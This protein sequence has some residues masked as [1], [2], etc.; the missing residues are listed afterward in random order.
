MM[1]TPRMTR[2]GPAVSGCCS[3][4]SSKAPRIGVPCTDT[5]QVRG[6][7]ISMPPHIAKQSSTASPLLSEALRRSTFVPPSPAVMSPPRKSAALL[8]CSV[9]PSMA[10]EETRAALSDGAASRARCCRPPQTSRRPTS[11]MRTGQRWISRNGITPRFC[12]RNQRPISTRMKPVNR[13]GQAAGR[14]RRAVPMAMRKSG[15]NRQALSTWMTPRLSSRA[16]RPSVTTTRPRN[17]RGAFSVLRSPRV[18]RS[19]SIVLLRTRVIASM[20][21]EYEAREARSRG[22]R[23][24]EARHRRTV[25]D[26]TRRAGAAGAARDRAQ[27]RAGPFGPALEKRSESGRLTAA[28]AEGDPG[29]GDDRIEREVFAQIIAGDVDLDIAHAAGDGERLADAD[30]EA[31]LGAVAP[32]RVEIGAVDA[33][34]RVP[35]GDRRDPEVE[36]RGR[37][38][39]EVEGGGERLRVERLVL[40]DV[41]Q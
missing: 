7:M 35:G 27:T 3:V 14:S 19:P 11:T 33:V 10:N 34:E 13:P 20:R 38:D 12:S 18:L 1:T 24:T 29:A 6:T 21:G 5:V 31:D 30:V 23:R 26:R 37:D 9:P 4:L 8:R 41:L 2:R 40:A 32:G 15:Q 36:E 17:S 22:I 16:M 28:E 39:V 25:A